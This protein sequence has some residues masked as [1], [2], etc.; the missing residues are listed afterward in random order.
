VGGAGAD[1]EEAAAYAGRLKPVRY[2]SAVGK[3]DLHVHTA[4]GDGMA[5]I[6][7]LLDYVEEHTDLSVL[8]ITEHDDLA[9]AL[10]ARETSERGRH[11][12]EVVVGE[13]I[14]TIEGHVIALYLEAP[15]ASLKHLQPTLEAIH[16]QGGLAI[17][18]HPMSWLTR[19][20]GERSIDRVLRDGGEGV[21][22]D[23]IE[24]AASPAGSVTQAKA[25]RLNRERYHLA[26]VGGSDAHFLPAIG[27]RYTTFEGSTAEELRRA[28]EA[29]TTAGQ[30]NPYPSLRQLGV[31]AVA[32]Q[33]WRGFCVTPRKMGWGPTVASFVRRALP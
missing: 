27:A 5:E 25:R 6:P 24:L 28:I 9:P 15:V 33:Q 10:A 29:K 8:A 21:S 11:R 12:F 32:R 26:E 3:A 1:L 4:Q 13:E 31:V 2:N 17:I 30:S 23:A 16:R 14:T 20:V 19:S 18:P 7:E 22:F